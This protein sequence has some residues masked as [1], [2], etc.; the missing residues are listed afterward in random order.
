MR[1]K[2]SAGIAL[3]SALGVGLLLAGP[4]ASADQTLAQVQAKV[5]ALEE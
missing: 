5:R 1:F 4:T 3:A 2:A